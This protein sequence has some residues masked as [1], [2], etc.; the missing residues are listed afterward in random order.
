[1]GV[2]KRQT[3]E[4]KQAILTAAARLFRERGIDGVGLSEIMREAGFTHGGFYNHFKSKDA[5]VAEVVATAMTGVN[6]SLC[7]AIAKPL[8]A[9]DANRFARQIKYY[10]STDHRDDAQ[11]TCALAALAPDAR[12]LGKEAQASYARGLDATLDQ[13]ASIVERD[14]SL[15]TMHETPRDRAIA[16]YSQML[17]ALVLSRAVASANQPLANEILIASRKD[18]L[19]AVGDET[20]RTEVRRR[21]A[22]PKSPP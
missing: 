20:G 13:L 16:L 14:R 7:D 17:G 19:R 5:L 15:K 2:S 11:R 6:E 18:L 21:R 22:N 3:E 8:A 10:L 1:M 4:N 12:R 9:N